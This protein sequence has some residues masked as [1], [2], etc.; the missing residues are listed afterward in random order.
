MKKIILL[1]LPLSIFAQSYDVLFLGNS[2]T[3]YNQMP[4]MVSDIATSMGDTVVAES[5]TPA[6]WK[7]QQHAQAGSSSLQKI[8]EKQWDFVVIQAQSQEPSFP[9]FQVAEETYPYAES[10]VNA[11]EDNYDCTEPIFYMTWGRKNGDNIN[12]QQ[13]PI[14][15]TYL[16]MQ[17]RLRESYLEMGIDNEATVAPVGMAWK[18]SIQDNPN[19]ELYTG[20]ESHP[21]V[22]GSYLAACV[23]YCTIFQESCV[24]SSYLPNG[25]TQEDATTLQTIASSL[26]LDS[27]QVWNMFAIQSADTVVINDSTYTFSVAA[28]NYD[29]LEWDFGDSTTAT[30]STANHTFSEG[31]HT[32]NL[33]VFS[34]GEGCLEKTITFEIN[35]TTGTDTTTTDTTTTDSTVYISDFDNNFKLYP[36]PANNFIS[37]EGVEANSHLKIYNLLG[38]VVLE[39]YIREDEHIN[40][41]ALTQGGQYIVEI[42]TDDNVSTLKLIKNK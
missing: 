20:D 5:N 28:S 14:I 35:I 25:I 27:T 10:L 30:T 36:N 16:G 19:F 8:T 38:K 40:L 1:L 18:K 23:F 12:G 2:Y 41:S 15:S 32:V 4:S 33:N 39:Q 7:L 37:I 13:Y 11:I 17:Q 34:N 22:A 26:V 42:R 31:Q 9:P 29:N 21:N 3:F 6:G 24:G